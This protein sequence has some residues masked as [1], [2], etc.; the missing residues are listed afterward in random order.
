MEAPM[1]RMI[2]STARR[3][4]TSTLA[5]LILASAIP[6]SGFAQTT[7]PDGIWK[8]DLAKSQ[9][10]PR[11]NT[12]MIARDGQGLNHSAN[13]VI[14]ISKGNV[15]LATARPPTRLFPARPFRRLATPVQEAGNSF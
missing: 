13:P 7:S 5:A 6:Q 8:I 15:Y 10:G 9:F 11:S 1:T 3:T 12:L 4:V 14:V 2:S